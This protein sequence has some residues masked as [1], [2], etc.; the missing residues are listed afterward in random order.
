MDVKIAFLNGNLD[1][2]VYMIQP[3]GSVDPINAGKICKLQ[4]TIY[5]LMSHPDLRGKPGWVSYVG[6]R[7]TIHI[8]TKCIE[9]NV[10]NI[11]TKRKCLTKINDNE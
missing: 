1:E 3:E 4:K 9:I 6:Q 5:G 10:T 7:R 11:I 2:D 8:K